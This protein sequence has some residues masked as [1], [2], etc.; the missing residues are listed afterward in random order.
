MENFGAWW[1]GLDLLLKI[2]W[3]IAVPFTVFFLLQLIFS[4]LAGGDAPDHIGDAQIDL[5]YDI[6]FQFLTLKNLVGFFTIF[7]WTGIACSQAGLAPGLTLFISTAAGLLMMG[8]MAGLFYLMSKAGAD[9]TMK[10]EKAVGESGVVYLMVPARRKGT[11]KVQVKVTGAERTLEAVTDDE[12]DI[13]A[14][15]KII[16]SNVIENILLVIAK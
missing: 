10:F 14:G 6:P 12:V 5:D 7:A 8:L 9:G 1:D 3:G 11:G 13:P 4:F 15:K 16:V 2:Y